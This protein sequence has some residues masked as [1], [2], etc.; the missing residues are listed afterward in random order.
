MSNNTLG[1][2]DPKS[3]LIDLYWAA[4]GAAE[5]GRALRAALERDRRTSGNRP[6]WIIALGK[7]AVGMA[8]AAVSHLLEHRLEPAGGIVISPNPA[9]DTYSALLRATGDHP[10]PGPRSLSAAGALG[11]VA[12][13]VGP[14]DEA[15][16]LLSGG[17]TSLAA[18]PVT[19]I[20][21]GDLAALYEVLLRSG[22]DIAAMNSIRKRFSRWGAG[23][24]TVALNPAL[25]WNFI[26]SDV[27]GNDPSSVGS[28][29]CVP[30]DLRAEDVRRILQEENLWGRIPAAVRDYLM[31]AEADPSL[32]T[33]KAGEVAFSRVHTRIVASNSHSLQASVHRAAALGVSAMAVSR[34]VKGEAV[35]VGRQVARTLLSEPVNAREPPATPA[36][37]V[38]GGEPVVTINA[39]ATGFGGRCQ[40][41]ALAAA[42]VLAGAVESASRPTLLAAGTDGR[43]G[44]TDAAGAVV[45]SDTWNA[46]RRAGRDPRR[47]LAAHDSYAALDAAG[48]L[49]RTGPTGTNVM[50]LIIGLRGSSHRA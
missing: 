7:A 15:W 18:A 8:A 40:E 5:P 42:E 49:I 10:I 6:V 3:L 20:S 2:L 26:V 9:S 28:G 50:D 32:E 14:K 16:V 43:D 31:A 33:P 45:D 1:H 21:S 29:P 25:V 48:A 41:L 47:D 11:E 24:L 44:P 34:A 39:A 22:M 4:V 17:A 46:V 37:L 19:G 35:E 23:R 30:D 36:C 13:S 38:W 12:G 27:V